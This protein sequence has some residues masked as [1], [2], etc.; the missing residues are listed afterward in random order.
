MVMKL[1]NKQAAEDDEALGDTE[2]FAVAHGIDKTIIYRTPEGMA[3][4]IITDLTAGA[5]WEDLHT[6]YGLSN[7]LETATNVADKD[8]QAEASMLEE[9]ADYWIDLDDPSTWEATE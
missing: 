5:K 3:A 6:K 7:F 9:D 8:A 1:S 2:V 4:Q